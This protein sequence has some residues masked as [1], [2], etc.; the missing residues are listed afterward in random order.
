MMVEKQVVQELKS[1]LSRK[2][3]F[4][5]MKGVDDDEEIIYHLNNYGTLANQ[6][7]YLVLT[8][9]LVGLVLLVTAKSVFEIVT[10]GVL[11]MRTVAALVV[12][13]V[14]VYILRKLLCFHKNGFRFLFV[15]TVLS[16]VHKHNQYGIG[17]MV[18]LAMII[19]SGFLYRKLFAKEE[20]LSEVDA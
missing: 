8:L 16:L 13:L 14:N 3:V 11:D 12:P 1:G 15:L 18:S 2:K 4:E 6:K 17:L 9:V 10:Y 5:K 20:L 19:L 7:K